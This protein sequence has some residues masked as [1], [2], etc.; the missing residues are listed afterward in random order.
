[1][2]AVIDKRINVDG[3]EPDDVVYNEK[4]KVL[5]PIA[6]K[7][8]TEAKMV[9]D[10][11]DKYPELDYLMCLLLIQATPEELN[12][13][14]KNPKKRELNTSTIIK[15]DFYLEEPKKENTDNLVIT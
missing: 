14:T 2:S 15:Q 1:M 7:N 4:G 8:I 3:V 11:L 12:E 6:P 5:T 10:M 9:D 13:L